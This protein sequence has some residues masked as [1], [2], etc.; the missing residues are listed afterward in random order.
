[1][2]FVAWNNFHVRIPHPLFSKQTAMFTKIHMQM[3]PSSTRHQVAN[4]AHHTMSENNYILSCPKNPIQRSNSETLCPH[5]YEH[6]RILILCP[7]DINRALTW[8]L[9]EVILY[10]PLITSIWQQ[11]NTNNYLYRFV[12][13]TRFTKTINFVVFR[14]SKHET[15]WTVIKVY[16][17]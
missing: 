4:E 14:V 6:E 11:G 13:N 9:W 7:T 1:M 16:L 15:T 17:S 2:C 5:N 8:H 10:N 3:K 12:Q